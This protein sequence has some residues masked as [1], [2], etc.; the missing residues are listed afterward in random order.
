MDEKVIWIL[1]NIAKTLSKTL[2]M[3]GAIVVS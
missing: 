2:V 3:H 1:L